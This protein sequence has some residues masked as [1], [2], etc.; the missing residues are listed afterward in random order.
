MTDATIVAE[1]TINR[2]ERLRVSIEQFNG[3]WLVNVRKWYEDNDGEIC[4]GKHGIALGVKHL[5]QLAEAMTKALSV[6]RELSLVATG[7][8]DESAGE[9]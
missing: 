7:N 4:P 9:S 1:W 5:P 3:T 2:R 8:P 6:A